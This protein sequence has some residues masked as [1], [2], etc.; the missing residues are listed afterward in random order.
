[1]SHSIY[2]SDS[3][4]RSPDRDREK[5]FL[6][7]LIRL[8][9]G[10]FLLTPGPNRGPCLYRPL[11]PHRQELPDFSFCLHRNTASG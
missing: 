11:Y 9:K 8:L 5:M 6:S 7:D 1:M 4:H 2:P 3:H 10:R